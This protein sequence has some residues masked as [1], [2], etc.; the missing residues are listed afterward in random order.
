MVMI[1][2]RFTEEEAR[3]RNRKASLMYY[4]NHRPDIRAKK[5]KWEREQYANNP[6]FR[7][8]RKLRQREWSQQNREIY[9]ARKR[10]ERKRLRNEIFNLLGNR[11]A[12]CGFFDWRAFQIDHINGHGLQEMKKFKTDTRKYL[13]HVLEVLKSGDNKDYQLLCANCNQIKKYEKGEG[14]FIEKST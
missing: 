10:E 13:V 1:V 5:N 6:E 3:A 9:C 4:Y 11:C 7:E 12:R 14:V 8:R 2:R